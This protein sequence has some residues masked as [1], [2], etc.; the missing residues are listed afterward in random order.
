MNSIWHTIAYKLRILLLL[1]VILAPAAQAHEN[2]L[3]V[4]SPFRIRGF[5]GDN[6]TFLFS[7]TG[8]YTNIVQPAF[9]DSS[10]IEHKHL[11]D[12][13]NRRLLGTF[14]AEKLF[15][16]GVT[17]PTSPLFSS[18]LA[19]QNPDSRFYV[20]R[21]TFQANAFNL[22]K[23]LIFTHTMS[24]RLA[25][26]VNGHLLSTNFPLLPTVP[27]YMTDPE[28]HYHNAVPIPRHFLNES[29]NSLVFV[30]RSA[31]WPAHIIGK[32]TL[33]QNSEL[34]SQKVLAESIRLGIP[35]LLAGT[36][37]LLTVFFLLMSITD[38]SQRWFV[39]LA[40]LSL[41]GALTFSFLGAAY[42]SIPLSLAYQRKFFSMFSIFFAAAMFRIANNC[43]EAENITRFDRRFE[44]AFHWSLVLLG[45]G[46]FVFSNGNDEIWDAIIPLQ[47]SS[48]VLSS[49]LGVSIALRNR[50]HLTPSLWVVTGGL[51]VVALC[52]LESLLNFYFRYWQTFI[53][54]WGFIP[55]ILAFAYHYNAI[56]R[57]RLKELAELRNNL[58]EKVHL[59]TQ[60][61][62]KTAKKLKHTLI[63]ARNMSQII[64]QKSRFR[65][66][67]TLSVHLDHQIRNPLAII[68]LS[69]EELSDDIETSPQQA[70]LHIHKIQKS[71]HSIVT[72][73]DSLRM[74]RRFCGENSLQKQVAARKR[75]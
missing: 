16:P 31:T 38:R 75:Q 63:K 66:V 7:E 29:Q 61:L 59:R 28:F 49:S 35:A 25:V 3:H 73:L 62:E 15:E 33:V 12:L 47:I 30:V 43:F 32:V 53:A 71:I 65:E 55:M 10:W 68:G 41:W 18:Y 70:R 14:P 34:P 72:V 60:E 40:L 64:D 69:L 4:N 5:S 26:F 58:E 2:E 11:G 45:M 27:K 8:H 74:F 67:A 24:Y 51:V 36:G 17:A 50:K 48:I 37:I 39:D 44:K 19:S 52:V 22:S 13:L 54:T 23:P 1:M 6:M 56:Y 20:I 9:D 42:E 57:S 21:T 46:A